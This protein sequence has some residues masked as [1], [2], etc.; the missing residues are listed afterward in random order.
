[1]ERRAASF[2]EDF[3]APKPYIVWL[4][5]VVV[6]KLANCEEEINSSLFTTFSYGNE[7]PKYVGL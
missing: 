4:Q 1:M 7:V 5:E 3:K 6:A 2:Q